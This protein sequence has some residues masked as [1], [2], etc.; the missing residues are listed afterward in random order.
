MTPAHREHGKESHGKETPEGHGSGQYKNSKTATYSSDYLG[1]F[2]DIGRLSVMKP[3]LLLLAFFL[4]IL[5]PSPE[6]SRMR[7]FEALRK[8]INPAE[9]L[10]TA[11]FTEFVVILQLLA[12]PSGYI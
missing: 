12:R 6:Y 8:M 2:P 3:I 11:T 9:L 4:Q 10:Q 7:A 1:G 5:R